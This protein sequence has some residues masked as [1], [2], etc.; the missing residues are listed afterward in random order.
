[1]LEFSEINKAITELVERFISDAPIE[2]SLQPE[3]FYIAIP[4]LIQRM[5]LRH[6]RR[7]IGITIIS[8]KKKTTIS[9]DHNAVF[10]SFHGFNVIPSYKMELVIFHP[11]F[12]NFNIYSL[13]ISKYLS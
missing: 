1:M 11:E 3:R 6:Y 9:P 7:N 12:H 10:A 13:D 8:D 2:Y 5:M 4:V